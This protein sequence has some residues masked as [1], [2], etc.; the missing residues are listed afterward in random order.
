[1]LP[2]TIALLTL[3]A[4]CRSRPP[5]VVLILVDT[6]RADHLSAYRYP[7]PISP[8]ID[9]FA[10]SATLFESAMSQAPHTLPSVLQI[11][12]SRYIHETD[13]DP[14]IPTL[15]ELLRQHGYQTAAVVE[16]GLFETTPDA[17]GLMRGFD[18]FYRNGP[19]HTDNV[20]QQ[21][22]KTKTPAD[23]ITAQARRWL[24]VRDRDRPFFLWLHYFD[25][26]DPY[27]PPFADD[28]EALTWQAASHF[29]GD[30]RRTFLYRGADGERPAEF[31]AADR[32][33]PI[34]LYDGEIRYL[35]Q[36]IGELFDELRAEGVFDRSMIIIAADH[37]ESFGEHG[38]W[39]H[40]NSL[41]DS[42]VHIP[43]I[44]K[45]PGQARGKR[46]L[47]P[48]QAI[49]IAPTVLEA[50]RVPA[51]GITLDGTSLRQRPRRA[52]FTFWKDSKAVRTAVWKLVSR[53]GKTE[54]FHLPHDPQELHDLAGERPG[55][56][57]RLTAAGD[58]KMAALNAS[59][60]EVNRISSQTVEQLRALGYL[61]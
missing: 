38:A 54:L 52:A 10:R 22:W 39:T 34:D 45:L 60:S 7:Q 17:H 41:Y 48:V 44:V 13:I 16:N 27:M 56:V 6:L 12:T 14:R 32:Q 31:T 35:D 28:M 26:H 21:H 24:H 49:D 30:I 58:A 37:G 18:R 3:L 61:H 29:T 20:E 25:P 19:L 50:A 15:A 40:G 51:E 5:D 36:S 4:G 42:E 9:E 46:V 57:A 55:V 43:L 8:H 33:H 47:D 11:M 59:P 1:M 53:A 23:C 2:L